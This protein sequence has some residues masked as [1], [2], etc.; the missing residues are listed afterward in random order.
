MY[1]QRRGSPN[2]A[3]RIACRVLGNRASMVADVRILRHYV[4]CLRMKA[5]LERGTGAVA[6][7]VGQPPLPV[8][9]VA[10]PAPYSASQCSRRAA[11]RAA[12]L[13]AESLRAAWK[14]KSDG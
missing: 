8:P 3:A 5:R 9:V 12:R 1:H 13:G 4:R 2:V 10:A 7:A 14:V 11:L 6:K